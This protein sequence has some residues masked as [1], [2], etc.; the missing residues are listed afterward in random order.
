M[1]FAVFLT[2]YT[3]A[4]NWLIVFA[5]IDLLLLVLVFFAKRFYNERI[6]HIKTIRDIIKKLNEL[7][8][9]IKE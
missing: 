5:F 6:T 7:G 8:V 3:Q 1:I 4:L 2:I 9:N